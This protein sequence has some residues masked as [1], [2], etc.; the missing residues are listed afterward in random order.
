[1]EKNDPSSDVDMVTKPVE[2]SVHVPNNGGAVW[3]PVDGIPGH[4]TIGQAVDLLGQSRSGQ[5]PVLDQRTGE[6]A[7]ILVRPGTPLPMTSTPPAPR[8]GGMA[9]PLGVY[10]HDG[11][12]GGGA[13]FFG[14]MLTG[15]LLAGL[16]VVAELVTTYVGEYLDMALAHVPRVSSIVGPGGVGVDQLFLSLFSVCLL[17][18]LVRLLP[19]AGTH[20]AEHQVVH[21][22][23]AGAPLTPSAVRSMPR[24]HPRCG[25]N[26]LTGM[27]I[28]LTA[29]TAV[30]R[31]AILFNVDLHEAAALGAIV[32]GPLTLGY[33]RR[34]GG[35]MQYWLATKPA[36]DR[37]IAG[38][39]KAAEQVFSKRS[40]RGSRPVSFRMVRRIW[41]MGFPQVLIGYAVVF[42][43]IKLLSAHWPWLGSLLEM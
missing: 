43:V 25:T 1:M 6:V 28:F 21:C 23:E 31:I 10:L 38:A 39:I 2:D 35:F 29:F 24:V 36:T 17:L 41:A 4:L 40:T 5:V 3:P 12:S 37:Q 9:T 32:A 15:M 8:L 34:V 26:V 27:L 14:L 16:G 20:A 33:W 13:G 18:S 19:L 7:G 30:F 42:G 22:V 11:I